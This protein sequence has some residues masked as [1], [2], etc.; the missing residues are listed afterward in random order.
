MNAD[1]IWQAY[2][3]VSDEDLA[4][5]SYDAW[6]FGASPDKLL[7]LVLNGTKKATASLHALY[8]KENEK[9]PEKGTYSVI[10]DSENVARCIIKNSKVII[11]PY[12]DFDE[13]FA[14][15]EGEG[16]RSLD[17]WRKVHDEFFKAESSMNGLEFTDE[18]L[19]VGEIF[20]VVYK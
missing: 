11:Q 6:Q 10:L 20:E 3:R 14:F 1:E 12:K 13:E 18:S 9:V 5:V 7:Q 8:E 19:V 16:D 17:Y 2:T 4:N 15:I